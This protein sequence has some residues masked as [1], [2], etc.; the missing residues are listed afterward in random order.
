MDS[1]GSV[2]RYCI[3]KDS[4]FNAAANFSQDGDE[5]SMVFLREQSGSD[6]LLSCS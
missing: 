2:L 4:V 1:D 6:Y 5:V 3:L